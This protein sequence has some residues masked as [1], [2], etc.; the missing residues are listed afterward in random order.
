MICDGQGTKGCL[1]K[2]YLALI[3]KRSQVVNQKWADK[4]AVIPASRGM[5]EEFC[6]K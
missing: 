6:G 2:Q 4:A 3:C 5:H 1:F